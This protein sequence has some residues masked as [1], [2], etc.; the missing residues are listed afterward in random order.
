MVPGIA[1]A[2][3]ATQPLAVKKVGTGAVGTAPRATEP[4][5]AA[6]PAT[7]LAAAC[8][9]PAPQPAELAAGGG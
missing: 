7:T 1:A 2:A 5:L 3:L 6:V 4:E 8:H 9:F